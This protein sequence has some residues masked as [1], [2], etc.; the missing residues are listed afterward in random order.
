[1]TLGNLEAKRDWGF[2]GD[3]VNAMWRML[4]QDIPDDYVIATGESRS[5]REF[6]ETAARAL[7]MNVTWEGTGVD[8]VGKDQHG[9]VIVRISERFYRPAEVDYLLG[10]SGKARAK[11]NW[12]PKTTF[13]ELVRMMV[14]SDLRDAHFESLKSSTLEVFK[15]TT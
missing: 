15:H 12:T 2:A 8:E 6:V 4:Q 10:D 1:V 3:Y 7:H 5:V 14:I 9:N 13:E 11:L